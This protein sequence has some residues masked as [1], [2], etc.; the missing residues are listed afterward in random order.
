MTS[1]AD[2]AGLIPAGWREWVARLP[3]EGGPSG[4]DWVVGLPRRLAEVLDAWSL[5]P[6]GM[7]LTGWTAVV[8]PVLHDGEPAMLKVGWPHLEAVDEA[9]ALRH[10]NGNGAVRLLAADPGRDAMLLERLDPT[11]DL[12]GPE[13]PV[14]EACEVIGGILSRLHVPAPPQLRTL[15]DFADEQVDRLAAARDRL[16]RRHIARAVHLVA[17]LTSAADCNATLLHTDLHFGNVLAGTREPWLGIDPKPLAGHPGFEIQPVLRNRLAELGTGSAFRRGVR[18]RFEIVCETAGIDH[19]VGRAWTIV[20]SVFQA[21][22]SSIDG[23]AD[24]VTTHLAIAKALD[25]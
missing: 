1:V 18:R 19:E 2:A 22:W 21:N 13:V 9:L 17:A 5:T 16:P 7:G 23:N 11:R 10:W 3:A 15:S 12:E 20:S 24:D 25:D 14:D 8:V 6:T 4:A